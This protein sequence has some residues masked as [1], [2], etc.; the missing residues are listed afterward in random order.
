MFSDNTI[1]PNNE[2]AI[3]IATSSDATRAG[4]T[5]LYGDGGICHL[6]FKGTNP[7]HAD[8]FN[9]IRL[10]VAGQTTETFVVY[11]IQAR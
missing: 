8:V 11:K 2:V 6:V 4:V 10:F 1:A 9:G 5:L 3:V 7:P